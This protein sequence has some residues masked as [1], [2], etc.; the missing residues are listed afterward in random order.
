M[1]KTEE[2]ISKISIEF[3]HLKSIA[4]ILQKENDKKNT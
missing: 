3:E 2:E 1:M 4:E